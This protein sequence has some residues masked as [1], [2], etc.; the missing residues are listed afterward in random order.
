[1]DLRNM[2]KFEQKKSHKFT[3]P[4]KEILRSI[5]VLLLF[6]GV[7][8]AQSI[9]KVVPEAG[10]PGSN[11]EIYGAGFDNNSQVSIGGIT[12]TILSVSA[13]KITATIHEVSNSPGSLTVTTNGLLATYSDL[14]TVLK[15]QPAYFKFEEES[16]GT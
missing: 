6:S 11:I 4:M 5:I 14:F 15:E 9:T 3:I 1:M 12:A 7:A 10:A 8:F 13:N 2:K 16:K